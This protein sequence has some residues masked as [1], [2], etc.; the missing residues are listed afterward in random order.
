MPCVVFV[1]LGGSYDAGMRILV[2]SKT[3]AAYPASTS[4]I[5]GPKFYIKYYNSVM[6]IN[7]EGRYL[8]HCKTAEAHTQL[9]IGTAHCPDT[10]CS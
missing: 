10:P 7:V 9:C 6:L 5:D 2:L 1:V 3:P 4:D 8:N